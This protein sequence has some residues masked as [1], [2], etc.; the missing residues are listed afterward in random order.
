MNF[1]SNAIKQNKTKKSCSTKESTT[2]ALNKLKDR[3]A[4]NGHKNITF[5]ENKSTRNCLNNDDTIL[6]LDFISDRCARKVKKIINK[7]NLPIRLVSK[8]ASYLVGCLSD[9]SRGQK[10]P[11]CEVCD[12]LPDQYMCEDR[13]FSV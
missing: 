5:T 1:I 11:N 12:R 2:F 8:P 3:L 7:H 9:V 10:H 13:F 4:R 6:Q